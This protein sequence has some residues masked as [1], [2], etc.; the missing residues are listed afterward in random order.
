VG[1]IA[2][3]ILSRLY[4]EISAPV[5]IG[6]CVLVIAQQFYLFLALLQIAYGKLSQRG[7]Q[8]II[9]SLSSFILLLL[10]YKQGLTG[11]TYAV[12]LSWIIS[13]AYVLSKIGLIF[14]IR[15]VLNEAIKLVRTGFP[16]V[17][18]GLLALL[19]RSID[20]I[21]V[22]IL[23][24]QQTLGYYGIAITTYSFFGTIFA[25]VS[26]ALVPKFSKLYGATESL[27][28][29][30]D[31]LRKTITILS[32]LS[33][34]PIGIL[35]LGLEFPIYYILPNY[36]AAINPTKVTILS[37]F[38]LGIVCC[39][40]P[41]FIAILQTPKAN[42]L[43]ILF[44]LLSTILYPVIHRFGIGLIGIS[45]G[46]LISFGAY[47]TA[48]SILSNRWISLKNEKSSLLSKIYIPFIHMVVLLFCIEKLI[49]CPS[50]APLH[51]LGVMVGRF[52]FFL[53]L[54][55]PLILY[56][57]KQTKIVSYIKNI[58]LRK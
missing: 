36:K 21:Y 49:P 45:F 43:Q 55:I 51:A 31:P 24:D 2:S 28:S 33:T 41:F 39:L 48:L 8:E 27:P 26:N 22:I 35:Y 5:A 46:F 19:F 18:N 7:K 13:I 30:G 34:I 23:F 44:I 6:F 14:K 12:A 10:L 37:C 38:F 1:I 25:S 42:L 56:I 29:L 11:I 9:A 53:V 58:I 20:R 47:A 50:E 16:I 3:F 32:Y 57:E 4:E 17:I 40:R 15:L 54:N 52:V